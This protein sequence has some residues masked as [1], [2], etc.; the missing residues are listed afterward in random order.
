MPQLDHGIFELRIKIHA[1]PR[2]YATRQDWCDAWLEGTPRR[3]RERKDPELS[4]V[5]LNHFL[6]V[7]RLID[8]WV[9]PAVRAGV[10][11]R[12]HRRLARAAQRRRRR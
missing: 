11:H 10:R 6:T 3:L 5:L 8:I 2:P 7:R 1:A 12:A 4:A 9:I